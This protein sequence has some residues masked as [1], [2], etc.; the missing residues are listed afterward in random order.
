MTNKLI[1]LSG[2]CGAGKSEVSD[3]LMKKKKFGFVRFGQIVMD[4]IIDLAKEPNE[5]L[6]REI[7]ESFRKEL[8]MAAFAILNI[9]K[10]DKLLVDGDV[11]GDG[12]MSWE[13]YVELKKKY[14]DDIIVIAVY[15]PPKIRY[16]RL[17]SRSDQHQGDK[18]K[19]FRDF[20]KEEAAS[21]DRAEIENL[22][23]AGPIAMA[24]YTLINTLSLKELH[25]QID[26][27]IE[28]IYDEKK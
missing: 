7:R 18:S 27:I 26:V 11:V 28:E 25:K 10:F 4:K 23:K 9:P 16:S 3:Y 13:E 6:E 20:T 8:G 12:L 22:H 15:A 24:D 5:S 19:R 2:M 1:C 14:K 21:R 17:E